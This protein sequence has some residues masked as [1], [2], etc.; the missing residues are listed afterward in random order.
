MTMME[1][2][3]NHSSACRHRF[4]EGGRVSRPTS[5]V[6]PVVVSPDMASKYAAVKLKWGSASSR[7]S[8]AAPDSSSQPSVTSRKPS[9]GFNSR[10]KRQVAA[11]RM[12]PTAA[13]IAAAARNCA[14]RPSP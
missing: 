12:R 5:T 2:P 13:V 4:T 7:G 3:P 8:A 9:R 10:R 6:E 1:S 11:A 14:S